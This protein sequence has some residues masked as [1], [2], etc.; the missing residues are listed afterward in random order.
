MRLSDSLRQVTYPVAI[1]GQRNFALVWSS[2]WTVQTGNQMEALILAWYVLEATGSPFLVGLIASARMGLNFLALFSGAIADRL[3]RHRLLAVIELVMTCLGLSI[4]VLMLTGF[5]QVWHLFAITLSAGLVRIFQMPTAQ[6]L[7][8]D[9]L[10]QD[11]ISNGAALSSMAQNLST[12]LGPFIGGILYK[13]WGPEGGYTAVAL[14][15]FTSSICAYFVRPIRVS[16]TR[17]QGSVLRTVV[18]GLRYVKGQQILWATLAIAVIIN[19]TGWPFHT[20]LLAI[21]AGNVL[22]TGPDGL[23][24]LTASFGIGALGG[25][26][27]WASFRNLRHIG[28][29]MILSVVVWHGSMLVFALSTNLYLSLAILLVTG[30][31]FSSTQVMM[32]TAMLRTTQADYRGRVLG[33]RVLAIYAYAFGGAGAGLLAGLWGAPLAAIMIGITGAVLTCSLAVFTPQLRRA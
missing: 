2:V 7:I 18:E 20:A 29:L 21:F 13:S 31:A 32:L 10:P 6:A 33:L 9:T 19:L 3:T 15:Y 4:L 17:H 30:A 5:L 28:K 11:K 25:S 24:L 1:L 16:E 14:L 26:I 22:N 12:I 8:G 27:A 23:G